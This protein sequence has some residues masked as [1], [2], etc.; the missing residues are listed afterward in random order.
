M[1]VATASRFVLTLADQGYLERDASRKYRLTLRAAELGLAS[2][3]ETGLCAHARPHLRELASHSGCTAALGVLDGPEVLLV[4]IA[5]PGRGGGRGADS[6]ARPGRGG[7]RSAERRERPE[8]THLPLHCTAIGKALL[9]GLP[10]DWRARLVAE[11]DFERRGPNTILD[12]ESLLGQLSRVA[13]D[14]L[15]ATDDEL[16]PGACAIAAP[17][18]DESGITIAAAGLL[19]RDHTLE[20]HDLE[21]RFAGPLLKAAGQISGRLGWTGA[22]DLETDLGRKEGERA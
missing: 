16:C 19:A 12:G 8:L 4:E 10:S 1:S 21:G 22:R 5:R 17:V 6:R 13:R 11:V 2:I 9:A 20:L 15:A 7:G 18:R 3:S 14:G